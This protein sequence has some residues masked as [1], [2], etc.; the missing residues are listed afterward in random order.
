MRTPER[1]KSLM[2]QGVIDEVVRPLMSGKEA[3]VYLVVS[4]GQQRVAKVYKEANHRSF[5]HRADYTEGRKHRNTR[6][7][8]AMSKRSRFGRAEVEAAWRSAE[9]DAIYRLRAAGVRVPEP[10]AFVDGVLVMELVADSLGQPAPRLVDVDFSPE[11]AHELFQRL[12]REVVRMLCAGLVHGDLSDFNVLLAEEGPIIIDFPQAVDPSHNRNARKL[13]VRDVQNLTS[14]L[15][16]YAS[17]LKETKYGEEMWALYENNALFP[18]T[19]LTGTFKASQKKADTLSLL[20]E[21][22]ELE[23]EARQRREALGLPTRPA[24]KP[25][26]T[27]GPPPKPVSE[28]DRRRKRRGRGRGDRGE[29]S[30]NRT[31]EDRS[32]TGDHPGDRRKDSRPSDRGRSRGEGRRGSSGRGRGDKTDRASSNGEREEDS[33]RDGS[34]AKPRGERKGSGRRGSGD[35]SRG[36]R[37]GGTHAEG[38]RSEGGSDTRPAQD[39][40]PIDLDSILIFGD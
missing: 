23:Q 12:I 20:Q 16:R 11:E 10:F 31:T 21:I 29:G 9:V 1:L 6:S 3:S 18:D 4:D 17:D 22:E 38:S 25:V 36:R 24:R 2:D 34:R 7:Q 15:A 30:E 37:D 5:K 27:R 35:R 19:E 26:A 39:T 28:G 13:L 8:R 33:R 14:F 40:L 32:A